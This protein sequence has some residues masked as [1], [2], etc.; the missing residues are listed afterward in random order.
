M[1]EA[2]QRIDLLLNEIEE[3]CSTPDYDSMSFAVHV[4]L[5]LAYTG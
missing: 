2:Q 1:M 5:R 3:K 4:R